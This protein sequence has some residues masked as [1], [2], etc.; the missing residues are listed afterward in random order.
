[1]RG[2]GYDAAELPR[3]TWRQQVTSEAVSIHR[4]DIGSPP[5]YQGLVD[6]VSGP[7]E[8]AGDATP[9]ARIMHRSTY[10]YYKK[11]ALCQNKIVKYLKIF[12]SA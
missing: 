4:L 11:N 5:F 8:Q 3:A 7:P 12:I 2:F 10:I 9:R 6:D 1:M